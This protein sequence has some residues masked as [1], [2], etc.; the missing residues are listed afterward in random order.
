M[1]NFVILFTVI[2]FSSITA[3]A[4]SK[5]EVAI[6]SAMNAQLAAWNAGDINSFMGTYWSD[7][8]H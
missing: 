1:K 7:D 2:L 5:D 8:N 4:Q 3:V 6:R